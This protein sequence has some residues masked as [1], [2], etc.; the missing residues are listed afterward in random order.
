[1]NSTSVDNLNTLT[2]SGKPTTK[3]HRLARAHPFVLKS[4]RLD[5][6]QT[7]GNLFHSHSQTSFHSFHFAPESIEQISQP[8]SS[9]AQRRA[10]VQWVQHYSSL[11]AADLLTNSS[12]DFSDASNS[13]Q[14][15]HDSFIHPSIS[16]TE[17]TTEDFTDEYGDFT[18]HAT[19]AEA[20]ET[21]TVAPIRSFSSDDDDDDDDDDDRH[22]TLIE[23]DE[24]EQLP[25]AKASTDLAAPVGSKPKKKSKTDQPKKI[26]SSLKRN[27]SNRVTQQP[28]S[29]ASSSAQGATPNAAGTGLPITPM[30]TPVPS[31]AKSEETSGGKTLIT[32][33]TSRAR[34]NI[35]VVRLCLREM[36]WKEV[37]DAPRPSRV[38]VMVF[39]VCI[40][41]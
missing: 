35:E 29:S 28:P 18:E 13:D 1:M 2:T 19:P 30:K 37:S 5:S 17:M 22:A 4:A 38:S 15:N 8:T 20:E 10:R 34:S 3:N 11:R 21:I 16:I 40:G 36:G 27:K 41:Q 14:L 25:N 33:D 6:S 7:D 31:A 24:P 9:T 12:I 23:V 39:L 32:V 26:K